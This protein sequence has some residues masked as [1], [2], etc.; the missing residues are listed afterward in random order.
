MA[1]FNESGNNIAM[2]I[3]NMLISLGNLLKAETVVSFTL[4]KTVL[5]YL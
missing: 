1:L 5:I 2:E 3:I 4:S